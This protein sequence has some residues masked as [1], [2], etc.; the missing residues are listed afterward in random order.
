M[1]KIE[2]LANY[3]SSY[4]EEAAENYHNFLRILPHVKVM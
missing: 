2:E 3:M 4:M 1:S